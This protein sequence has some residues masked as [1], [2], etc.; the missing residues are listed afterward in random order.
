MF[1]LNSFFLKSLW[2]GGL[3]LLAILIGVLT[4]I[5][6]ERFTDQLRAQENDRVR[7]W[8]E[9]ISLILS[10]NSNSD[11]TMATRIIELNTSIPL[12]L[13]DDQNRI[14]T[15]RNLNSKDTSINF[16]SKKL[17]KMMDYSDPITVNISPGVEQFIYRDESRSLKRLRF[18]PKLFLGII[19]L[20]LFFAYLAFSRSRKSEQNLV[21]NGMAKE[22]AHQLGT[23]LSALFGWTTILEEEGVKSKALNEIK[24][25][26][27]RLQI[28]ADRFSKIGSEPTFS[29]VDIIGLLN[30]SS[31]YMQKRS[32]KTLKINIKSNHQLPNLK[33]EPVLIGWVFENLMRN[34]IDAMDGKGA[35]SIS[36][37]VLEKSI[38]IDFDDSGK[39]I[40]TKDRRNIFKPGFTTKSRGWGLG[41]SLSKR[42]VEIVHDGRLYLLKSQL[43]KGTVFRMHLKII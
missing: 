21:W 12:I 17:G 42:I 36:I 24:K 11:L 43:D 26:L 4:L 37:R 38:S 27:S 13:T 32:S 2:K 41:L 25:D 39:G 19:S 20:Y 5:Y 31:D 1:K 35:L 15:Y 8:G 18:F 33:V 23:P 3:L 9:A 7:L 6:T 14:L 28:V 29:K 16:L 34:A 22:T 40:S 10:S 30:Q